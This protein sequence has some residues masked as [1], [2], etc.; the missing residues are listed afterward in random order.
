L[1]VTV[2]NGRAFR[3]IFFMAEKAK[4]KDTASI[5]N[6]K[7]YL[8]ARFSISCKSKINTYKVKKDLAGKPKS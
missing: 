5:P 8:P 2:K 3:Y 7:S 4:K 1:G 6:A